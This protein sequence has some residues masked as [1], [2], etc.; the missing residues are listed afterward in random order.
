MHRLVSYTDNNLAASNNDYGGSSEL[1]ESYKLTLG[2]PYV[3]LN[4]DAVH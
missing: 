3:F 1:L 2:T 4:L